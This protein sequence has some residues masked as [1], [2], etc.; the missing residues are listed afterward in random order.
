M[1]LLKS[2]QIVIKN[3]RKN[4]FKIRRKEVRDRQV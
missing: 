4:P 2:K 3:I 1:L